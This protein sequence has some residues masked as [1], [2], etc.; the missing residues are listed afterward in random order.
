MDW[1][2]N[3]KKPAPILVDNPLLTEY[4]PTLVCWCG[5]GPNRKTAMECCVAT[6]PAQITSTKAIQVREYIAYIKEGNHNTV[7]KTPVIEQ[8]EVTHSRTQDIEFQS[9]VSSKDEHK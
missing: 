2:S 4:P 8:V 5:G 1:K 7:P 6:T 3:F 9:G